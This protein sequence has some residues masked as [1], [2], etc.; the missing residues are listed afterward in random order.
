M[1]EQGGRV[2]EA[3]ATYNAGDPVRIHV[4]GPNL[5]APTWMRDDLEQVWHELTGERSDGELRLAFVDG[6]ITAINAT[7]S[8]RG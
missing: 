8:K 7:I 5:P 3:T 6:Q 2:S 1:G 4:D